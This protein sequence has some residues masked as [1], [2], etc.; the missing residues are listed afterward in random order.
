[1]NET[2]LT[3]EKAEK[4]ARI[5]SE[6]L[7][8]KSLR[9]FLRESAEI[10]D[11]A[12]KTLIDA[13]AVINNEERLQ[14]YAHEYTLL[15]AIEGLK[16]K[17][18]ANPDNLDDAVQDIGNLLR[19]L[20]E[21]N[22]QLA[23]LV[24]NERIQI[25]QEIKYLQQISALLK[26]PDKVRLN[27]DL[28]L[29]YIEKLQNAD[30]KKRVKARLALIRRYTDETKALTEDEGE[31]KLWNYQTHLDI[32][33]YT[34]KVNSYFSGLENKK[35]LDYFGDT[36]LRQQVYYS[37]EIKR[38]FYIVGFTYKADEQLRYI[39]SLISFLQQDISG[40]VW[41]RNV[42]TS[43]FVA[44]V[45]KHA[46]A[47]QKSFGNKYFAEVMLRNRAVL[48]EQPFKWIDLLTKMKEVIEGMMPRKNA[49][50]ENAK[51]FLIAAF[52]NRREQLG[53]SITILVAQLQTILKEFETA[54]DI[55]DLINKSI[56]RL[57]RIMNRLWR[58]RKNKFNRAKR[59]INAAALKEKITSL[60]QRTDI[61]KDSDDRIGRIKVF[62][63][64]QIHM[65]II[66]SKETISE[67][68]L[69][70]LFQFDFDVTK[71]KQLA[72]DVFALEDKIKG[73]NILLR[74]GLVQMKEN[75]QNFLTKFIL[76]LQ[77]LVAIRLSIPT[78][79]IS[80]IRSRVEKFRGDY[81]GR[82]A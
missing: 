11:L 32:S 79:E 66:T 75:I 60:A 25:L 54:K 55:I 43:K 8:F 81:Y 13:D 71:M 34:G 21:E 3:R 77:W 5:E 67:D 40:D 26:E 4:A 38:L 41:I 33:F 23:Q 52:A 15:N 62:R 14:A 30:I 56:K 19:K 51:N 57:R 2:T 46:A 24:S 70:P 7:F 47:F 76:L 20:Q 17:M 78:I 61:S 64:F 31:I 16:K 59:E 27:I 18:E 63:S 72:E 1:M 12:E 49:A 10:L 37:K 6:N 29:S 82:A 69:S 68:D 48:G 39:S 58:E 80:T 44:N 50:I 22:P 74:D 42:A 53:K 9:R 36:V 65:K 28:L 35:G 73:K 45:D